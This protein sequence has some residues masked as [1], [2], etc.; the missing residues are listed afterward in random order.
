MCRKG[1]I[2]ST[3]SDFEGLA[4]KVGA[5][6]YKTRLDGT[7]LD[8]NIVLE[9]I[10]G[11]RPSDDL[12]GTKSQKFWLNIEEREQFIEKLKE[13]KQV[14]NFIAHLKKLN[15]EK[16]ALLLNSCLMKEENEINYYSEGIVLEISNLYNKWKSFKNQAN[17]YENCI[18]N[19]PDIIV[20]CD[21]ECTIF[22][23][24]SQIRQILGYEENNLI[25]Q[26]AYDFL[27][28]NTIK[29]AESLSKKIQN[30]EFRINVKIR[31]KKGHYINLEA[32]G[33][34]LKENGKEILLIV[35]R[36][37]S[38]KKR[39]KYQFKSLYENAPLGYQSLD[40]K[41]RILEV[42]KAWLEFFGYEKEEVVGKWFGDY[43]VKEERTN[44]TKRF[45]EFMRKGEIH[46]IKF[47]ILKKN[48]E[49]AI[50]N[51]EGKIS[52][53]DDGSVKH[54]H[55]IM[56]DIT[57]QKKLEKELKESEQK[58]RT[59]F[60]EA[61]NP[62]FIVNENGYYID[63][64]KAAA[65]FLECEIDDFIGKNVFDFS[66]PGYENKQR[67]DHSPFYSRRTLRT[68]YYINNKIKTLILNVV[69]FDF[70]GELYLYGIGQ[71]IT[72]QLKSEKK[73]RKSEKKYKEAFERA[74][75]YK[76][77][78]AHDINN[79]LQNMHS[80]IELCKMYLNSNDLDNVR[81]LI[82]IMKE[83]ISRGEKL[84]SNVR[85][86]S[87]IEEEELSI[88]KV[89]LIHYLDQAIDITLKRSTTRE[90]EI[91][92]DSYNEKIIVEANEL[93]LDVFENILDNAVKYNES[94]KVKIQIKISKIRKNTHKFIRTEFIDN[95]IGISDS[96][97][98]ILF[99]P[100]YQKEKGGKGM[101]F[102]LSLVKKIV[103]SYDG[104]IWVEDRVKGD[105]SKGAKFIIILPK[106][107]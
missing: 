86:L 105:Y 50:V 88:F 5:G 57:E 48:G 60:E 92:K 97:K 59:L 89:D 20:K 58:Y 72:E 79:A 63:G 62:I 9:R 67:K 77:L 80:S 68:E 31:H 41:G 15:G 102:G 12:R 11:L 75:F 85:K 107:S 34:I 1:I 32:K 49:T 70:R 36:N 43:L 78:F 35:L 26:N 45:K 56:Y 94:K 42:N 54:T 44:F 100:G 53:Y 39:K 101:G 104:E 10:F 47:T 38:N 55:C 25:G 19:I 98:K 14:T 106:N 17:Y 66:P 84:V 83:Q 61:L 103:E 96:K 37:L 29:N 22:F 76:D 69:P 23:V 21:I 13:K 8:Y 90:T 46:D 52:Y 2:M 73:I 64:N 91:K 71:D 99:L 4:R 30:K 51:Y 40:Q 95:G 24:S 27:D 16:I 65:E 74:N 28:K 33:N 18:N 7:I 81:E 3:N 93:L 82:P 6:F 87:K